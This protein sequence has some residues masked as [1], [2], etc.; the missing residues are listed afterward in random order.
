MFSLEW[1]EI[2]GQKPTVS[3]FEGLLISP[4]EYTLSKFPSSTYMATDDICSP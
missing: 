2:T 3:D 4:S 1:C